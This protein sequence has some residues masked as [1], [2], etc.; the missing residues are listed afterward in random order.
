MLAD[1]R[2]TFES[3]R[4]ALMVP[5]AAVV[6]KRDAH[7]VYVVAGDKAAERTVRIESFVGQ[8]AV[9]AGGLT[10]GEEIV[11][12]GARTLASGSRIERK[13]PEAP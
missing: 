6:P 12:E 3:G 5:L 1:A 10:P 9:I 11:V 2:L 7:A 13:E 8:S 4:Q